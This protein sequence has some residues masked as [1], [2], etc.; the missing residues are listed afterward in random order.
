MAGFG[1]GV[2]ERE[3]NHPTICI[4]YL[5]DNEFESIPSRA[6][7]KIFN[8]Q[9]ISLSTHSL[10]SIEADAFAG[11]SNI[12][13]LSVNFKDNKRINAVRIKAH[14]FRRIDGVK[15]MSITRDSIQ[16][17]LSSENPEL[18]IDPLAFSGLSVVEYCSIDS[19]YHKSMHV[20]PDNLFTGLMVNQRLSLRLHN[21]TRIGAK[22]FGGPGQSSISLLDVVG[23]HSFPCDCETAQLNVNLRRNVETI[24]GLTCSA[25][26]AD[27]TM[28]H[29]W[30][31]D[32]ATCGASSLYL[33]VLLV[34][35]SLVVHKMGLKE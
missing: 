31:L 19:F 3:E 7:Q 11:S 18:I 26:L 6:F 33:S 22:A 24:R 23:I 29:A 16:S 35:F 9:S 34:L 30:K 27:G 25:P 4:I 5:Q 13:G 1:T 17:G 12:G 2:F 15:L 20:L 10:S 32:H 14:A 21:I 28:S 8:V